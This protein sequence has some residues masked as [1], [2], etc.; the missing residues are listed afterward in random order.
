M[1]DETTLE[2]TVEKV[3]FTNPTNQFTVL[4]LRVDGEAGLAT[5]VGQLP[6]LSPG[7]A[8]RFTGVWIRDR[9]FG[10]QFQAR[11]FEFA[12]P[13]TVKGIK[14]Y[15]ASGVLKGIGDAKAQ[16]IVDHLGEKTLRVIEE[17]PERL[18]EVEGIGPALVKSIREG[19]ARER[20]VREV[21]VFLQG[22]EIS[23]RLAMKIW[24][25]YGTRSVERL[26]EDPFA[27]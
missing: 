16:R 27:V 26:R 17:A 6:P 1:A 21:M 13:A 2:G 14:R 22:H 9:R 15:L 7:E 8:V 24:K 19:W 12:P 5:V 3:V 10:R 18:L 11:G 23:P 4:R 25:A 20:G